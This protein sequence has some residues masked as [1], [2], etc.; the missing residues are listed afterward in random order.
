MN[1]CLSQERFRMTECYGNSWLT[2]RISCTGQN[3][4]LQKKLLLRGVGGLNKVLTGYLD[5]WE[6]FSPHGR[7]QKY[8]ENLKWKGPPGR[9]TLRRGILLKCIL[10]TRTGCIIKSWLQFNT[11]VVTKR[12]VSQ[13]WVGNWF[14]VRISF[15]RR[16]LP[17]V[18]SE[19]DNYQRTSEVSSLNISVGIATKLRAGRAEIR[20]RFPVG[21]RDFSFPHSVKTCSG[22][23]LAFHTMST[24]GKAPETWIWP[25]ISIQCRGWE[26]WS[27]I[28]ISLYVFMAWC[29]INWALGYFYVRSMGSYRARTN[30]VFPYQGHIK[31]RHPCVTVEGT[32][33]SCVQW[34]KEV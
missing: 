30:Y 24:G 21:A 8:I 2:L 10:K 22:A 28:S 31:A 1:E 15:P 12:D 23:H 3:T 9:P 18:I 17:Y 11:L 34:R 25:V 6:K 13:N 5:I 7:S 19:F 20:V 29:L 14:K 32:S 26:W 27:Y 33:G 16:A 4:G